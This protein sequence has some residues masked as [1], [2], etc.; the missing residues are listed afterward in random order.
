MTSAASVGMPTAKLS[1]SRVA[2]VSGDELRLRAEREVHL[3]HILGQDR[4]ERDAR[5]GDPRWEVDLGGLRGRGEQ[6]ARRHDGP[7]EK[8]AAEE[9]RRM[10]AAE[11]HQHAGQRAGGH[12]GDAALPCRQPAKWA[13]SH[14]VLEGRRSSRLA[15]RRLWPM[16][17]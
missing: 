13:R 6:E 11:P 9:R 5:D 8:D 16:P 10:A 7:A 15:Q 12:R 4:H 17:G 1:R 3:D 14:G 2:P